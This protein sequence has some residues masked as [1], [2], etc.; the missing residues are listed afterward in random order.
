M[1]LRDCARS[2]SSGA[3]SILRLADKKPEL[4]PSIQ[5]QRKPVMTISAAIR[6][7]VPLAKGVWAPCTWP[8][9]A[10]PFDGR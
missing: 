1:L 2:V 9:S 8:S 10:N 3:L 5:R 4:R 7:F 6:F